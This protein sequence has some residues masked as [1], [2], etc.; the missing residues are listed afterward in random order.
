MNTMLWWF[1]QNTIAIAVMILFVAAS[2]RLFRNRPAV[3]HV[4][5]VVVLLKFVT[6]PVVSWPWSLQQVSQ[7]LRSFVASEAESV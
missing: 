7:S 4:L 3:Q 6:P 2:C 5:W 1:A